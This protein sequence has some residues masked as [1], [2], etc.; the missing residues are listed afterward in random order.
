MTASRR[1]A[2]AFLTFAVAVLVLSW[3]TATFAQTKK[4]DS[5]EIEALVAEYTKFEDSGDMASQAKMMTAD[6]WWHGVGGRHTDNALYMKVQEDAI[7]QSRKRYPG[8]QNIREVRDLK[9]KM[10]APTVAVC[11]WL[12]VNNRIIPGD[13]PSDKVTALGPAPI[14]QFYSLVW[15]KQ[16]DGWKIAST[17]TSPLYLR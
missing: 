14:P 10:I 1:I 15:V 11:S 7:T 6:R 3:A 12:W 9:V 16:S 13:L 8:L 2:R 17:H 5:E 4:S